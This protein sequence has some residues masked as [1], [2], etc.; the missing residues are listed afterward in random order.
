MAYLSRLVRRPRDSAV[1]YVVVIS[2][3][4]FT[5][6][7][8]FGSQPRLFATASIRLLSWALI[9]VSPQAGHSCQPL[10]STTIGPP[11]T[12]GGGLNV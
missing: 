1:F 11:G 4:Y 12:F 10:F 9:I 6:L 3:Y 2:P 8:Y 5:F 7:L